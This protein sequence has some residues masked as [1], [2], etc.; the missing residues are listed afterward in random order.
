MRSLVQLL[1]TMLLNAAWQVTV[2]TLLAVCANWLLRETAAWCR[3]SVWVTAIVISLFLPIISGLNAIAFSPVQKQSVAQI[4]PEP[5]VSRPVRSVAS[6]P[7]QHVSFAAQTMLQDVAVREKA[8]VPPISLSR[9]LAAGLLAFYTLFLLY[10]GFKLFRAWRRTAV[11]MRCTGATQVPER[12]AAIIAKCQKAI[13][14]TRV[15]VVCSTSVPVPI[16]AGVLSPVIILPERLLN[17]ADEEILLS[18]IGHELVHVA[19]RDYIL[20]LVYELLYLP[21]SFHP[22]AAVLRRRIRQTRELCCDE[23]VA[24]KLLAPD[25]YARS[26]VRLIGSV[27]LAGRL[28]PDTTIGITDADILEVRIMSLLKTSKLSTRRN[29]LL[30]FAAFLLLSVPCAAAAAFALQFDIDKSEAAIQKGDQ[31][32]ETSQKLERAR[33]ELQRKE[34]E[35]EERVQKNVN[36]QGEELEA[37]RRMEIE[38]K[39]ASTR[40]A[41]EQET[42]HLK[43][44]ERGLRQL[45]ERLAQIMATQPVDEARMREVKERLA[46]LQQPLPENE[47]RLRELRQRLEMVAKQY[48]NA[49]QMTEHLETLRRAQEGIALAQE[50]MTQE[51]REKIEEKLKL[52]KDKGELEKYQEAL[53]RAAKEDIEGQFKIES[54]LYE[55]MIRKDLEDGETRRKI[56]AE[57]EY[58]AKEQ[59]SLAQQATMSMDRAIQIAVSQHPGKVLSCNLGRQKD[60]QVFYRL[61]IIGDKNAATHVWVSATDGQILKTEQE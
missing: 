57:G 36:P 34:R 21:L 12:A 27:P 29:T 5:N 2:V 40:L 20:N 9:N 15:R 13:G 3:H 10:R 48:P 11:I 54:K 44:T 28:V 1:L 37:Q 56:E 55:K 24:K 25:I 52:K 45:H 39:E 49:A 43:E 8:L 4:E 14:V 38:L 31:D 47:E 41:Q 53:E 22:A 33:E 17:E 46:Q 6:D 59:I 18:A 60:G 23:L 26:L 35:L 50:A 7:A 51:K 58:R 30:L 19:R 32:K 42:L 61:V 16:T